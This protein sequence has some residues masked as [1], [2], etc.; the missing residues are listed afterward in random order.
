MRLL[1]VKERWRDRGGGELA[2]RLIL[3][4]LK[5]SFDVVVLAGER[6]EEEPGIKYVYHPALSRGH[7]HWLWLLTSL[8]DLSRYIRAADVVYIPRYAYPVIPLA[9]KLGKRVVVHLHGY[10]PVSYTSGPTPPT[11]GRGGGS[12]GGTSPRSAGRGPS[13][14]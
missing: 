11:S 1:V 8:A 6:E 9:K 10:A 3:R 14:A 12:R 7:R 4:L 2:T 5:D 13:S